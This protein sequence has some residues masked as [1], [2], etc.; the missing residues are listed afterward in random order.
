MGINFHGIFLTGDDFLTIFPV[1]RGPTGSV[2]EGRILLDGIEIF[3]LRAL[4]M[5]KK[6]LLIFDFK[7]V[8]LCS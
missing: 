7:N 2:I 1:S 3:D 5:V 6:S 4:T 8:I